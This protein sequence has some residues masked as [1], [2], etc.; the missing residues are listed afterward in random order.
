MNGPRAGTSEEALDEEAYDEPETKSGAK[1]IIVILLLALVLLGGG[2]VAAYMTGV[3]GMLGMD[4]E[5]DETAKAEAPPP[6]PPLTL[7]Y[8]LP[9]MVTNLSGERGRPRFL[10]FTVALELTD[11]SAI[12]RLRRLEP[13]IIDILQVHFRELR[14]DDL[15]D[16]RG[17]P[18]L[19]HEMLMRINSA[20]HPA[21]ISSVLL[22][23]ILIQ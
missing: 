6:P 23:D 12:P 17:I 11:S 21:A 3:L 20:I 13:R 9:T 2:G 10:K 22:K 19:R 7:F 16:S 18:I 8:D 1:K 4:E 14:I 5:Q 15:R